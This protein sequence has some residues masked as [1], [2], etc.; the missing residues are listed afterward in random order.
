MT[1]T[2]TTLCIHRTESHSPS[3]TYLQSP[4]AH[5]TSC[6]S[7]TCDSC[8]VPTAASS[9]NKPFWLMASLRKLP[10]WNQGPQQQI[11]YATSTSEQPV[12]LPSLESE[13]GVWYFRG[14]EE[15][16]LASRVTDNAVLGPAGYRD[17]WVHAQQVP[18]QQQP[19]QASV[20]TYQTKMCSYASKT[21]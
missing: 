20:S 13:N 10:L 2:F 9:E 14:T 8:T 19:S 12:I 7:L 18:L 17:A 1:V 3:Q 15:V 6:S 4:Q 5:G 21:L 16:L 11:S